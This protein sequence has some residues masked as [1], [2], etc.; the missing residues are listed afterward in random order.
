MVANKPLPGPYDLGP[1]QT[2]AGIKWGDVVAEDY[3]FTWGESSIA[4]PSR[5]FPGCTISSAP[6]NLWLITFAHFITN[7]AYG[8]WIWA[9]VNQR[10]N[11]VGQN[12]GLEILWEGNLA[13]C[14]ETSSVWYPLDSTGQW[15]QATQTVSVP[16]RVNSLRL[17]RDD[18]L[19][20]SPGELVVGTVVP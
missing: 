19:G 4:N 8:T 5:G 9:D 2:M 11:L 14:I 3:A 7:P 10:V 15:F 12:S 16:L 20:F 13:T 17:W 6:P 1:F 18:P